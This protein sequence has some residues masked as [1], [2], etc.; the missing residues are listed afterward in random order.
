MSAISNMMS[1]EAFPDVR[2]SLRYDVDLGATSWFRCGGKAEVFFK[3]KD[4][5]DLCD[6][7][8]SCPKDMPITVLGVASN[9]I[10]RDGGLRGVVIRLGREFAG[11]TCDTDSACVTVGAAALD[12]NVARVASEHGIAGLEFLSGIPGTIGGALRMNAGAYGS[13]VKDCLVSCEAVTLNGEIVTYCVDEMG[14]SY[15]HNSLPD[16]VI[17][18]SAV[19]QGRGGNAEESL[20]KIED[21]KAKRESTQPIREKTGG[22]TFANPSAD[23]L[24]TAGLPA[25]TK[26]WM[27]ID[28]VGGRGF[29]IGG[30]QMSELH[31]N[32]MINTGDAT[33]ADLENL[34]EEMRKRVLDQ[35]GITLRWEIKRIGEHVS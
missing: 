31:C 23:E 24:A 4:T 15:R 3:P 17:F 33:A 21:I 29:K 9:V 27:L 28:K 20:S 2:G 26:A 19:F 12:V 22:S 5:T 10:I 25:D 35:Y 32:F 14:L 34:G 18:T 1:K 13:E 8:K 7:L 30:A 6:F 16:D 11:I